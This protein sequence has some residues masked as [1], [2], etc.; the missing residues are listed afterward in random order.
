MAKKTTKEEP[1]VRRSPSRRRS[2]EI[3]APPTSAGDRTAVRAG[4]D[5]S[6]DEIAQRAYEIYLTRGG[7]HGGELDDW[8]EAERQLRRGH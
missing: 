2:N 8:L 7:G 1:R 3:E 4:H 5:P 6:P